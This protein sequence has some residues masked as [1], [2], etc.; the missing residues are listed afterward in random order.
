MCTNLFLINL[1]N[2]FVFQLSSQQ[3][4]SV[5]STPKT[6][7]SEQEPSPSLSNQVPPPPLPPMGLLDDDA[8]DDSPSPQTDTPVSDPSQTIP[9]N[10]SIPTSQSI[11]PA[12]MG[13]LPQPP[14][15]LLAP[16]M[17][18]QMPPLLPFPMLRPGFPLPASGPGPMPMMPGMPPG[19][20]A[21]GY[22]C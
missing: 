7:E 20:Q 17:L 4:H 6:S 22:E 12:P 11:A 19:I 15:G 1:L 16:P 10:L 5:D 13:L 3:S 18:P 14:P 2:H 9:P 8:V 21:P